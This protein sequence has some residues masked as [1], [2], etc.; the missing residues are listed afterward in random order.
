MRHRFLFERDWKSIL[1]WAAIFRGKI[2]HS[3]RVRAALFSKMIRILKIFPT[4]ASR[5]C[6]NSDRRIL[7]S[8]LERSV[9]SPN[10]L[11][12][13]ILVIHSAPTERSVGKLSFVL[14]TMVCLT[15]A[16]FGKRR[17]NEKTRRY[18]RKIPFPTFVVRVADRDTRV[19]EKRHPLSRILP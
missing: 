8:V 13:P 5:I 17:M 12:A 1:G 18:P 2:E 3:M 9:Y 6:T 4:R 19:N 14:W 11:A 15:S 7:R 10:R 16:P